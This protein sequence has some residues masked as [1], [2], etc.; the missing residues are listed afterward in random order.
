MTHVPEYSKAG[1]DQFRRK[2]QWYTIMQNALYFYEW[3]LY[4]HAMTQQFMAYVI[5][6]EIEAATPLD[7]KDWLF[8]EY[9]YRLGEPS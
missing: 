6:D 4:E 8:G 9:L 5:R 1:R 7:G 3:G 2:C